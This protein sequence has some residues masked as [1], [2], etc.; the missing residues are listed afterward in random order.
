MSL[1]INLKENFS[2][3]NIKKVAKNE[4]LFMI[5]VV[6]RFFTQKNFWKYFVFV[7]A[8]YFV[9]YFSLLANRISY[10]DDMQR[11][12]TGNFSFLYFSRYLSEFLSKVIHLNLTKNT[13]I[14]PIPQLIALIFVTLASMI[15]VKILAKKYN[16]KLLLASCI[17]GLSP[18]YLE[19]MSYKFD[20][21]F[22]ALAMLSAITPFLFVK[23]NLSFIFISTIFLLIMYTTY[24]SSNAIYI[25]LSIYFALL[26]YS[27]SMKNFINKVSIFIIGLAIPSII[28]R[29]LISKHITSYVS[30]EPIHSICSLIKNISKMMSIYYSA[31]HN[32]ILEYIISIIGVL[33]ILIYINKG[34]RIRVISLLL[35]LLFLASELLFSQGLYLLIQKPLFAPRA[36]Q[37]I[38]IFIAI[39]FIYTICYGKNLI[40]KL[41]FILVC[42]AIYFLIIEANAYGNALKYV[43]DYTYFRYNMALQDIRTFVD[44]KS[45]ICIYNSIDNKN[46][47]NLPV[48]NNFPILRR[49]V[50]NYT[51]KNWFFT[52][53]FM[54]YYFKINPEM[55]EFINNCQ[56]KIENKKITKKIDNYF[57]TIKKYEN[58]YIIIKFK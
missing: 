52:G 26:I 34:V 54:Q 8:V 33:F 15:L 36:V 45:K 41:S 4:Y 48:M 22:M 18:F 53:K 19:N 58:N 16:Y 28:Y 3:Q 11:E 43:K 7:Y 51:S 9:G 25:V 44:N 1:S 20:A 23:R 29:Y 2:W 38:S 32:T 55:T 37:G 35:G 39:V 13:D 24:Q 27:N 46:L 31:I 42:F 56:I 30:D 47:M 50:V 40:H 12:I 10:V 57:H 14:S 5:A 6:H 21:P 49:I 17:I